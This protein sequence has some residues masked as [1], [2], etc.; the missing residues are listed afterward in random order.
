MNSSCPL[1][2]F[3]ELCA[4]QMLAHKPQIDFRWLYFAL[5]LTIA[6]ALTYDFLPYRNLQLV[7]GLDEASLYSGGS[8]QSIV[9]AEWLNKSNYAFRCIFDV[10]AATYKFCGL[11]V[12]QGNGSDKG[13]NFKHFTQLHIS[14]SYTGDAEFLRIYMRN[15]T[16]ELEQYNSNKYLQVLVPAQANYQELTLPLNRFVIPDWWARRAKLPP[17][18]AIASFDNIIHIGVDAPHPV[19]PGAHDFELHS[20]SLQ[21][22]WVTKD[23]WYL[24]ILIFWLMLLMLINLQQW[25]GLRRETKESAI[26]LDE[27]ILKAQKLAEESQK[28]RELS[29]V[30]ELTGVLNRRGMQ[31]EIDIELRSNPSNTAVILLDLDHFKRIND[32]HGHAVGDEV[33]RTLGLLLNAYIRQ[34]DSVARWGGEEF[35]LLC[36]QT[37][38]AGAL[39]L[40]EKIRSAIAKYRFNCGGG[41]QITI[42]LGLAQA[43]DKESFQQLCHR[44]DEALY[45]AKANGRNCVVLAPDE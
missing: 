8:E 29:L 24:S 43:R 4:A 13:I 34:Q 26:Q 16:P 18:L 17:D 25:L 7:P 33:L 5:A 27:A 23:H 38:S 32:S 2:E 15:Y 35:M 40:A 19:N 42:S 21:G 36:P 11:D 37:Q 10:Q 41:L 31:Q 12:K 6:G 14:I 22:P 1:I 20:L 9:S 44:A 39:A 45:K 30:D 28:Y 3:T